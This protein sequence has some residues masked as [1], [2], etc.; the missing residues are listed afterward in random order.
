MMQIKIKRSS[1]AEIPDKEVEVEKERRE[2]Q[3]ER[4]RRTGAK[5]SRGITEKRNT[6]IYRVPFSLPYPIVAA[7]VGPTCMILQS[8]LPP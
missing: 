2:K 8:L 7:F 4:K 6:D 5:H 1:T 3:K